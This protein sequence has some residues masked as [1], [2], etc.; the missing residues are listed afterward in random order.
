[1]KIRNIS[2][3]L[4]C[5]LGFQVAAQESAPESRSFTRA[6]AETYALEHNYDIQNSAL[7]IERAKKVI[8]QNVAL[9]LPQVNATG[10]LMNNIQIQQQVA[11]FDPTLPPQAFAFGVQYGSGVGVQVDQLIFD[12]SYIVA[13]MATEV[14]KQT[15]ANSYE[16]SAIEIR[17]QVAQAYHLVLTTE[18]SLKIVRDN[19]TFIE[20]SLFETR[21]LFNTGFV[22]QQ[23]VDQLDLLLT[24]LKSNEDYLMKQSEV[25]R[26]ILK[27]RMGIPIAETI[28]LTDEIESL[29]L[30]AADG[31]A[32]IAESFNPTSH[33]DY[34]TLQTGIRGQEL[35][36]RN[37]Q[38]Q[39]LPKLSAFYSYNHQFQSTNLGNI[40]TGKP[41]EV[42]IDGDNFSFNAP[43]QNLGLSL[44]W[45]LFQGGAR[46][47][48]IQEARI[49]LDK[50]QN[51]E[52]QLTDMLQ[53][54]YQTAR[55]EYSFA[56]NNFLAQKKNVSI[57]EGIRDR[58]SIK[59]RE[60][61]VSSLEFT[62]AENQY[63]DALRNMINAA[64]S[65][66]DKRVNLEKVLGHF[67]TTTPTQTDNTNNTQQ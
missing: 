45:T 63:Q 3:A 39:W 66:L 54:Q 15:A 31:T 40:Y 59:F 23:D 2:I 44:R 19:I 29:V 8:F 30:I 49:E 62:Q 64:Q 11:Q 52:T 7:E 6:E 21:E 9:G 32:L 24:N 27:L 16:K 53:I 41:F 42:N 56:V 26:T 61:L 46:V 48:R 28:T 4:T 18:R 22:E 43:Y 33:I 5:M 1:M 55:A 14:V 13:L 58:T 47:A 17:E 34:R 36:L 51:Q 65:A 67:N 10:N 12:G 20:Q 25:A 37:E 35:T 50:L 57:A 38:V 60:G